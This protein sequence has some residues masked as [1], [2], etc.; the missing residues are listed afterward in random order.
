MIGFVERAQDVG[1]Q[2]VLRVHRPQ[3][4]HHRELAALVDADRDAVLLGGVD[5]DPAAA[6]GD[7]A[8][9]VQP[10]LAG[11]HLGDE[12]DAGAAVQ[13]AHHDAL[14]AVDDELAAAEHDRQVAQVDFFLDRLLLVEPQPDAER[15][16]VGQ[17]QLAAF[18][19]LV[20]R[21][22]E[23]VAQVLEL[24]LLVVAFDREDFAQHAFQAFVFALFRR[25]IVLQEARVALRLDLGEIGNR[26]GIATAAEASSCWWFPNAVAR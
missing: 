26:V 4:R 12:V 8:A 19:R 17:P 24:E 14:G 1:V 9:A 11:F 15:P 7:D 25:G 22:A 6:L 2:A 16:A 23:L 20:A 13:L 10:P 18:I 5:L 21:L 3:Q